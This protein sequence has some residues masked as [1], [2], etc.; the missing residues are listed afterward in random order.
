[1]TATKRKVLQ[2]RNKY[3]AKLP[4]FTVNAHRDFLIRPMSLAKIMYSRP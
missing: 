1:M 4:S 2:R 3:M